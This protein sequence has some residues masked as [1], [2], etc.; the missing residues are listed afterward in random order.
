[1]TAR[2]TVAAMRLQTVSRIAAAVALIAAGLLVGGPSATS[3]APSRPAETIPHC[4]A[5]DGGPQPV[6]VWDS[7]VDGNGAP[8]APNNVVILYVTTPG[9]DPVAH[10]IK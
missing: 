10:R 4:L 2:R 7:A 1:M 3:A 8:A 9:Q 5:E 6:C